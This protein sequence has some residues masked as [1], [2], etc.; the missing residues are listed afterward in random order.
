MAIS[1]PEDRSTEVAGKIKRKRGRPTVEFPVD[2][3]SAPEETVSDLLTLTQVCERLD[4][5]GQRVYVLVQEGRLH[6][7]RVPGQ[8]RVYYAAWEVEGA[9]RYLKPCY[10]AHV[11]A[12]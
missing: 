9:A 2:R 1:R 6:P 5:H 10:M 12:A 11:H 8:R 3:A 4:V 7:V